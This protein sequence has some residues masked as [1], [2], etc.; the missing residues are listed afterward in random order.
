MKHY[1]KDEAIEVMNSLGS[2]RIPFLFI[3]DFLMQS[4]IVIPLNTVDS[5]C[6]LYNIQGNSN[7]ANCSVHQ[8][9]IMMVKH[10]VPFE[11]YLAAFKNIEKHIQDGNSYLLNLTFPTRIEIDKSLTEIFFISKARYKLI[12]EDR[13]VVFSPES[14]VQIH[15]GV[16]YSYPMKGTIDASIENAGEI[17]LGSRKETAEH[18]TIVDL[19]RNDLSIIASDI[20]VETFRYIEEITTNEKK[21]LQVSSKISGFLGT[22]YHRQIGTM[23]FKLLP[24]GSISGAPK[25]KTLEI[26]LESEG[27][28]RGYYTGVFGIFNGNDLDSGIMIRYIEKINGKLYYKS[29]GGIT[30]LSTVETEYQEMI[31]K[32]YV[33]VN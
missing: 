29:G 7:Y 6:I 21:L 18:T 20:K 14:F 24:A 12:M 27:Y 9:K 19:I 4:P 30:S 22:D 15:N 11:R 3:I 8:D 25:K 23:M 1:S 31:D 26:I 10:P 5:G 2:R 17:I 16:I 33:P 28:D 32:V 13:F